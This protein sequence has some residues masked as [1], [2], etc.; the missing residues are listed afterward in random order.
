[1]KHSSYEHLEDPEDVEPSEQ[2]SMEELLNRVTKLALES[3]SQLS[4]KG[5]DLP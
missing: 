3:M 1:M 4:E 5:D 2:E